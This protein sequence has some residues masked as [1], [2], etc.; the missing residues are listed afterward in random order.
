MQNRTDAN[1]HG[2]VGNQQRGEALLIIRLEIPA[3]GNYT[4]CQHNQELHDGRQERENRP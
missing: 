2:N 4:S 1:E 3:Q